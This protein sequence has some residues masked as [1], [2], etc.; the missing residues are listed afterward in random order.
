[1]TIGN[2]NTLAFDIKDSPLLS[3]MRVVDIVINN[4][5]VC[6]IDNNVYVPQ[7]FNSLLHS[8]NKLTE[9]NWHKSENFFDEKTI[10]EIYQFLHH[11][12]INETPEEDLA[13]N[14]EIYETY[15]ILDLGPTTNYIGSFIIPH[16]NKLYLCYSY[17][18]SVDS[19][20]RKKLKPHK[21]QI[22]LVELIKTMNDTIIE[23]KKIHNQYLKKVRTE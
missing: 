5:Y 13:E 20:Q 19:Y 22:D 10:D 8:V 6:C 7:F 23:L 12:Y 15:R 21:V 1:M 16:N 14:L 11:G 18:H 2:K 4:E 3:S 17:W 9:I